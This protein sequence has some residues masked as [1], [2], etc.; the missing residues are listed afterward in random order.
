MSDF[1]IALCALGLFI[2]LAL[3]LRFLEQFMEKRIAQE[4][5][6]Q[7]S[8]ALG[9]REEAEEAKKRRDARKDWTPHDWIKARRETASR[10]LT[11]GDDHD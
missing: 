11:I 9:K 7:L 1:Q 10:G 3:C 8:D 2:F 5:A 4:V 6:D